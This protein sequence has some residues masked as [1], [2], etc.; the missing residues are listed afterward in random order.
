MPARLVMASISVVMF[1]LIIEV[2][3]FRGYRLEDN[4]MTARPNAGGA[5]AL[6][7]IFFLAPSKRRPAL[8]R[9]FNIGYFK[10]HTAAVLIHP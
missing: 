10:L 9:R 8:A 5:T 7:Y 3:T 2:A 6:Q 4:I 1:G